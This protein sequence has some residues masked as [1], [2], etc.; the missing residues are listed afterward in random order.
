MTSPKGRHI[1]L[2]VIVISDDRERSIDT[3]QSRMRNR[4]KKRYITGKWGIVTK[5][6][7]KNKESIPHVQKPGSSPVCFICERSKRY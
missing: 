6:K 1:N 4:A 3:C 5:W 2:V 7:R